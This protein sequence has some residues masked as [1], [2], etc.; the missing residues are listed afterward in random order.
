MH[1]H[2]GSSELPM[3][4]GQIDPVCGMTVDPAARP[5][6]QLD[7]LG[8][9]YYFCSKG[10]LLDFRDEPAKFLDPGYQPREM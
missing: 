2:H 5:D 10:C 9:T 4:G 6:L 8:R 3:A 1:E 7:H